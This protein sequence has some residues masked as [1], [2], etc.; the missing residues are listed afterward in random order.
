MYTH[1]SNPKVSTETWFKINT[2]AVPQ[3]LLFTTKAI[4]SETIRRIL[5]EPP[6]EP[7]FHVAPVCGQVEVHGLITYTYDKPDQGDYH[8]ES[9]DAFQE[10]CETARR[11]NA[12]VEAWRESLPSEDNDFA[13]MWGTVWLIED[14]D[15]VRRVALETGLVLYEHDEAGLVLGVDGAG[16]SFYAQYWYTLRARIANWQ[17]EDDEDDSR[18]LALLALLVH[19][20]KR[21]AGPSAEA[22]VKM[23]A[24]DFAMGASAA[25]AS[26]KAQVEALDLAPP[27]TI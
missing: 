21:N 24:D 22:F 7:E 3:N 19:E 16:F 10:D 12:A 18:F 20:G 14:D 8:E 2:N 25:L 6:E 13:P 23:F 9:Q 17:T 4:E 27:D 5:P 1:A 26:L 15:R 11:H